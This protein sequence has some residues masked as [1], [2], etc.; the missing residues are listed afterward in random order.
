MLAD[1]WDATVTMAQVAE[2]LAMAKPTLYRLVGSKEKLTRACVEAETE[3]LLGHLHGALSDDHTPS[4]PGLKEAVRAVERYAA[5]SP[6]GF[7]LLFECR[8]PYAQA[9]LSRLEA[10]LAGLL[11]RA[12][13]A[14]GS[15]P[16]RPDLLASALLG[17]AAAVVSRGLAQGGAID[18]EVVARDF[19]AALK[20]RA[21]A[22]PDG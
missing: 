18:A 8:G 20:P 19:G 14:A 16:R 10:S 17:A 6:G 13:Q 7:R 11:R 15:P 5:D 1:G 3:R 4:L 12:G 21:T 22:A 2:R 9:A